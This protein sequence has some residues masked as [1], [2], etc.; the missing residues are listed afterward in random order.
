MSQVAIFGGG[1]AGS[2]RMLRCGGGPFGGRSTGEDTCNDA[3]S[4]AVFQRQEVCGQDALCI[5]ETLFEKET[6]PWAAKN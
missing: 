5:G 4:Q 1:H 2:I 3:N 6:S